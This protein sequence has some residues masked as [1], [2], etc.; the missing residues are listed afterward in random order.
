MPNR[1]ILIADDDAGERRIVQFWL[2]EEGYATVMASDGKSALKLFEEKS[3][4]LVV[5]DIRMPELGGLDLL[6]RIKATEPDMP[7]ILM[8][9]YGTVR[10][11]PDGE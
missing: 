9:A 7:V 1:P 6:A 10:Q 3:P 4:F 11:M 8:T 5:S 2:E